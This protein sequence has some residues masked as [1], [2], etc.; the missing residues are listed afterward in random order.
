MM[1]FMVYAY[2][3]QVM[4][5]LDLAGADLDHVTYGL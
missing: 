2:F 3:E 1:I 4:I 5:I